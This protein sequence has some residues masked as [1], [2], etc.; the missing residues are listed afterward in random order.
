MS[1]NGSV[2]RAER[3]FAC[4][5]PW[6]RVAI[7]LGCVPLLVRPLPGQRDSE[8]RREGQRLAVADL[9]AR[10]DQVE[11]SLGGAQRSRDLRRVAR[12][13]V[14]HEAR[15]VEQ[16]VDRAQLQRAPSRIVGNGSL[17]TLTCASVGSTWIDWRTTTVP[18]LNGPAI[19][20]TV[21][22]NPYGPPL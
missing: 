18:R 20:G 2:T 19:A 15:A 21:T 4:A 17:I 9:E 6:V 10:C 11:L 1:D 16:H 7:R 5:D 13:G 12:S 3:R 22:A 14:D 8:L